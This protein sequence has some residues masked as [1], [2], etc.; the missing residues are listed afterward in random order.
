[1]NLLEEGMMAL[2]ENFANYT[3]WYTQLGGVH[4]RDYKR[5]GLARATRYDIK[6]K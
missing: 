1:M 4:G 6:L 3:L 5:A 2:Y